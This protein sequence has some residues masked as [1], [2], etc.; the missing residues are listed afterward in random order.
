MQIGDKRIGPG[1]PT[2]IVA[3][4]SAN[5]RGDF[6][7]A[8]RLVE[9][10]AA[11]GAAAVKLQLYT[12]D[13]LTLDSDA[14]PFRI[15]WQG[16][17]RTFHDLYSE[18]A[19]PWE[20][21]PYLKK[22]AAQWKMACFASVFDKASVD[23]LESWLCPAYKIASFELVDTPLIRYAASKGKPMIL[24]TGMAT[25]D[26]VDEADTAVRQGG[27]NE[28][29]LL[30]CVSGYPASPSEMQLRNIYFLEAFDVP[31]G[32]SDH[33]LGIAVPVAAVALGACM[34]EKHLTLSR[35]AGGPDA[36]FSLEP[37]EFAAMVEAVRIAEQ[38]RGE[39]GYY[40]DKLTESERDSLRYRR[41]LFVVADIAEGE[42][43]TE[44]NVRSIRPADGLPP[45]H[46]HD[47]MGRK[48]A[49]AVKR[50]VPLDWSMVE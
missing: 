22:L 18:A 12:P 27:C 9:V 49:R 47:I 8:A 26:E 20:W 40:R 33:T 39:G 38:A 46:I 4:L 15:T 44:A 45:K 42:P 1:E 21:Y 13:S 6:D 16:R 14:P 37:T 30:H 34:I 29:V 24:S 35:A 19:T 50:G 17:E 32:L 3:E 31:I 7:E 48:A 10:A 36:A 11:A 28:H 2:Y 43:F 5:H 23:F 41:S 25:W